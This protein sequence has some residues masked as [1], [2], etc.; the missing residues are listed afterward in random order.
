M[1]KKTGLTLE[2][3]LQIWAEAFTVSPDDAYQY[4]KY[5]S[6]PSANVTSNTINEDKSA[7]GVSGRNLTTKT[8]NPKSTFKVTKMSDGNLYVELELT[9]KKY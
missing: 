3:K 9:E 4:T 5:T 2:T 6:V 1:M 8:S 7:L